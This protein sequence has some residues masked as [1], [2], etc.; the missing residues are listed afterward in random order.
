VRIAILSDIHGNLD[1]LEAVLERADRL[2]AERVHSLGD[3]VGYGPDPAA[4]VAVVRR[5][6]TVS[7]LGNHD[8]AAVGRTPLE[9]FNEFARWAVEWTAAQLGADDRAYLAGLPYAA[10][11][12]GLLLVHSTPRAPERWEYIHGL[13]DVAEHFADFTERICCVGHSHRPAVFALDADGVLSR[14]AADEPLQPGWRYLVNAGSVGQPRD[15]DPRASFALYDDSG[16]GSL[17][18][19]RVEYP[20]ARTQQRM[21]EAGIPS[22]LVDRLAAGV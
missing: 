6:A 1:A 2:G 7:L 19:Q 5:R 14:R 3:I 20:V 8:A 13:P 9:D 17:S 15:R 16:P 4:C 21:R 11:E 22:F 12:G 10:R 18:L